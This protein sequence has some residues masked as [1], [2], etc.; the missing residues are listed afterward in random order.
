MEF[1]CNDNVLAQQEETKEIVP[2]TGH[3]L[4]VSGHHKQHMIVH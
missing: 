1:A 2:T 4:V 3:A